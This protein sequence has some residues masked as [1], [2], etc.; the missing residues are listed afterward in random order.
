[1]N[2]FKE[3]GQMLPIASINSVYVEDIL[4]SNLFRPEVIIHEIK[5]NRD[6]LGFSSDINDEDILISFNSAL[7][8][9]V[10]TIKDKANEIAV[11]F[12]D[13]LADVIITLMDPSALSILN[14][15]LWNS[16]H[17]SFWKGVKHI[18]FV[19]GLISPILTNIFY[20]QIVKR[21]HQNNIT[22][23]QISFIEGSVNL[24]TKGLSSLT[25]DGEYL[26]FD[27]GQTNI[28]RRHIFKKDSEIVIDSVLPSVKSKY[29]FYKQK[30]EKELLNLANKLDDFIINTIIDSMNI[31]NYKGN[32]I[33]VGIANYVY[34]GNIYQNRGGYGKL[35]YIKGNYEKHISDRISILLNKKITIRLY[36]DT[37]AM[38]LNFNN[39]S[40]TA[41]ISLGTAFGIAF[42][43]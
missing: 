32:D 42:P 15:P 25:N 40:R 20:N 28:K 4:A 22:D 8:S 21:L 18:Y 37:S 34:N 39:T 13:K 23:L 19:G 16:N 41:V 14:R 10:I 7:N 43:E 9:K 36:H 38:A 17:W 29:L 35:A 1:M 12:G 3:N 27:F 11:S 24:G 6:F 30:S 31:V 2:P 5:K 26:L 33:I